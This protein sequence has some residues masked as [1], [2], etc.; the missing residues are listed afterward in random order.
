MKLRTT[1]QVLSA[2]LLARFRR[3]GVADEIREEIESHLRERTEQYQRAGLTPGDAGRRARRRVGDVDV[4]VY[5]GYAVRGSGIM[6]TIWQDVRY[7]GR[8]L[9]RQPGFAALAILTLALGIGASTAI[10]SVI[11]AAI[12][13]P[14]P[15]PAPDELVRLTFDVERGGRPRRSSPS[16]ADLRAWQAA[17]T[18]FTDFAMWRPQWPAPIIDGPVPERG[19]ARY[20][21]E[22]WFALHGARPLVGRDFTVDDSLPDAPPVIL[23]GHGYWRSRFAADASV[24]GRALRLDGESATIVG[25]LAPGFEDATAIWRPLKGPERRASGTDTVARLRPG[26]EPDRAGEVLLAALAS[27]PGDG[28]PVRAVR[29]E[30]LLDSAASA[31]APT[32]QVLAGAVSLILLIGCVN[33]GG[34][35]LAR[36]ASRESELSA[37]K[38]LGASRGRL[39]RQL[40][41]ES[42]VLAAAAGLLGVGL[43]WLTLDA[44]VANLSMTLPATSAAINPM[45]LAFGLGLAAATSLVFGLMPALSL[46]GV[47]VAASLGRSGRRAGAALSRRGGQLLIAAEVAL[48]LILLTG[49]ALVIR[50]FDR[51]LS[52]DLGF[53]PAAFLTMEVVPVDPTPAALNRYY[54]DVLES[55][56]HVP[57]VEAVGAIDHLPLGVSSTGMIVRIGGGKSA[58][59]DVRR[60]LPGYFQA[61]GL[62]VRAGRP[63]VPEDVT[64]ESDVV[65]INED[66]A[67][68]WFDGTAATGAV[69]EVGGERRRV[70]GVVGSLRHGGPL[71]GT[72]PEAYLPFTMTAAGTRNTRALALTVVIR[73]H[74]GVRLSGTEIKAVAESIG[75]PVVVERIRSGSDWL[76]DRVATPRQRTVLLS[77]LGGLGL[78]LALVGIFGMTAY[79]VARRT[80]EIGVRMAFGAR[81]GQVVRTMLGDAAWPVAIGLGVGLVGAAFATKIIASFL[82]ETTPTDGPTFAAVALT[83]ALTATVAAWLPA[84]RA[85]RVDPVTA[86]RAE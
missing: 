66:A 40:L 24:V 64:A 35:L 75:P 3:D 54:A 38:A 45:V 15:Y 61:V 37:R 77:L 47:S 41:T 28:E 13:R 62:A 8:A 63:L 42:L 11:D 60:V 83:L 9:R 21:S 58:P 49:A 86:L 56:R 81:P 73:P 84:Q 12:L 79:A 44:L 10:F 2:R 32:A 74:P 19:Q 14:L 69:I 65:V 78:L 82:F 17:D 52:V 1:I 72:G 23:L 53:D 68:Q 71:R 29:A 39:T 85:A 26:V 50:S 48:A 7:A 34:L 20:V 6:E 76:G 67:R 22:K 59:V 4:H 80:R 18:P 55:L 5:R 46:S 16:M 70:V 51:I 31:Y 57:G 25:V 33:V 36:G 27:V 30:R 43:A